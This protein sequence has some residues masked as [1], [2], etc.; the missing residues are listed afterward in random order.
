MAANIISSVLE[1]TEKKAESNG[2][3]VKKPAAKKPVKA[4]N[5][6]TKKPSKK[7]KPES[8]S[9]IAAER[10]LGFDPLKGRIGTR[11]HRIHCVLFNAKAPLSAVEV[12]TLSRVNAA[13]NH[14]GTMLLREFVRYA[15]GKWSLTP[16]ARKAWGNWLAK[17]GGKKLAKPKLEVR[18]SFVFVRGE[19]EASK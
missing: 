11:T 5:K 6:P 13:R 1:A 16:E 4:G 8:A 7:T 12:E 19:K 9:S 3:Q 15:E 10:G 18:D 14:L 2:K 17:E